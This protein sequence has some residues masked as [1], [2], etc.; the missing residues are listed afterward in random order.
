MG[1]ERGTGGGTLAQLK[2]SNRHLHQWL[3]SLNSR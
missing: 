2:E 1:G 3:R